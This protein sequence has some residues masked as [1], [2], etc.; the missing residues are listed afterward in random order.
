MFRINELH[1][2]IQD[3]SQQVSR[4][5]RAE[6]EIKQCFIFSNRPVFWWSTGHSHRCRHR[7]YSST[8]PEQNKSKS[9]GVSKLQHWVSRKKLQLVK[10]FSCIHLKPKSVQRDVWSGQLYFLCKFHK[11]DLT[12]APG[13]RPVISHNPIWLFVF[14][15]IAVSYN[16]LIENV[17]ENESTGREKKFYYYIPTTAWLFVLTALGQVESS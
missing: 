9:K 1:Q 15:I 6:M 4:Q 7:T 5:R 2:C 16:F 8:S 14:R 13:T 17:A 10:P 11:S 12:L 3:K